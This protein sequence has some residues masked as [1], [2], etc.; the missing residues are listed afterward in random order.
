MN[1]PCLDG[2]DGSTEIGSDIHQLMERL[3]R[4]QQFSLKRR[5]KDRPGS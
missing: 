3:A 5:E 4:L 1:S 2:A